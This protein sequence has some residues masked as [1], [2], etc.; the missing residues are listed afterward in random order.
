MSAVL[1][2]LQ[3]QANEVAAISHDMNEV[4][5]G[6]QQA[7]LLPDGKYAF[8]R[9]IEYIEFGNHPQEFN[10]QAKDPAL[11]IQLG[12]ALYGDGI[13]NE[14]GT[15]YIIRPYRFPI[16]YNDRARSY[17]LFQLLNWD[18]TAT[19]FAQLLGKA[20]LV[21]ISN[22]PRS[23]TDQTLVSRLDLTTFLP[24]L[25]P[26]SGNPY[27]IPV[28]SDD[29][30]R[31]FFFDRPTKEAWDSL[32]IEGKNAKTGASNNWVQEQIMQALNFEGSALQLMLA[33]AGITALPEA[34]PAAPQAA[35]AT[36]VMP[37]AQPAI[38]AAPVAPVVQP[39]AIPAQSAPAVA[40]P[41]PLAPVVPASAI[42]QSGDASSPAQVSAPAPVQPVVAPVALAAPL[43]VNQSATTA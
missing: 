23:K 30:Y 20:W 6:G 16:K 40:A 26:V 19:H 35:I 41:T 39:A 31:A 9:L 42:P 43:V 3:A 2:A 17:S 5:V 4:Q 37:L 33:G 36:P 15:P 28:P 11:E 18:K 22:E 14:D 27:A 8:A 38:Q 7:R 32:Y 13:Q 29:L 12:F 21:K 1:A 10:G 25:D 24:P 34:A